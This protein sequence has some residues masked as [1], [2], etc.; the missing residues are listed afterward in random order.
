[1]TS[2]PVALS[3]AC[4]SVAHVAETVEAVAAEAPANPIPIARTIARPNRLTG[5]PHRFVGH[6]VRLLLHP[7]VRPP[8]REAQHGRTRAYIRK[9]AYGLVEGSSGIRLAAG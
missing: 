6:V 7:S 4:W 3:S 5:Y 9:I 1:M 2:P 8:S